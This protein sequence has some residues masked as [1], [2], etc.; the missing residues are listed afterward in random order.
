MEPLTRRGF[1]GTATLAGAT[2][3]TPI[4]HMLAR[5]AEKQPDRKATAQ[6]VIILW[7]Q[8]GPSQ[9]ET[10]DPHPGTNIAGGSKAIDTK[11]KGVQLGQ[12]K[13]MCESVGLQLLGMKRIRLGRV[14]MAKLPPGEWRY[15]LPGEKF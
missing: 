14:S 7:M 9:L 1:V 13:H 12:I 10:F 15:L 4:G 11:L 8:G 6:S 2:W 3:L 5:A